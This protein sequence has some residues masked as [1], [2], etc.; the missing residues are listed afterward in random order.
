[1]WRLLLWL[2]AG[3]S[4]DVEVEQTKRLVEAVKHIAAV[5]GN[6]PPLFK[7]SSRTG[8]TPQGPVRSVCQ[9]TTIDASKLTVHR[10]CSCLADK[11]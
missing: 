1:M 9:A 10:L 3:D 2:C 5:F 4:R 11:E 6:R 7:K 8:F